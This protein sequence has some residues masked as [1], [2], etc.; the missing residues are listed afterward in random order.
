[1]IEINGDFVLPVAV[2]IGMNI[3]CNYFAMRIVGMRKKL[4]NKEF[5][6]K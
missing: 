2:A 6:E 3:Q 1:M 5:M 4:F